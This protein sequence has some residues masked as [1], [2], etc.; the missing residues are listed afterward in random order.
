[1]DWFD[2]VL[3]VLFIGL[4]AGI[5]AMLLSPLWLDSRGCSGCL[6]HLPRLVPAQQTHSS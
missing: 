3:A 6:S 1:M 4:L 5:G 2:L